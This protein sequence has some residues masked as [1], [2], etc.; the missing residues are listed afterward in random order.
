MK[1]ACFIIACMITF[2]SAGRVGMWNFKGGYDLFEFENDTVYITDNMVA[3]SNKV[4]VW[5]I[6]YADSIID[7]PA[8]FFLIDHS[9]SM[10]FDN[11][12]LLVN[13]RY[14]NRFSFVS[15]VIDTLSI[16][17][18]TM[19]IGYAIFDGSMYL[20]D[21]S[22]YIFASYGAG[23]QAY[24]PLLEL[25]GVYNVDSRF[26]KRSGK[27]ILQSYLQTHLVP[28]D[29]PYNPGNV[30]DYAELQYYPRERGGDN[31]TAA[32]S[33][34]K[35]AFYSSTRP[36]TSHYIVFISDGMHAGDTGYIRGI[37]VP[38]TFTLFLTEN[39]DS[40]PD[41][42]ITM[43]RNIRNNRYSISNPKSTIC[44]FRDVTVS[45]VVNLLKDSI[46]IGPY[47]RP[48][49]P[50]SIILNGQR[51]YTWNQLNSTFSFDGVFPLKSGCTSFNGQ[52]H[53]L[54]KGD[55]DTALS[56]DFIAKQSDAILDSSRI[57]S[58][59][60][61]RTL[62]L[63]YDDA[64]ITNLTPA[65]DAVELRFT[66]DP[67]DALYNYTNVYVELRT[68]NTGDREVVQL[69][70]NDRTF[71]ALIKRT[72]S[73]SAAPAN[74]ILEN[75]PDGDT[76]LAVFRNSEA[77]ILPLDT[78]KIAIPFDP[79][80]EIIHDNAMRKASG[81]RPVLFADNG[82]LRI[83]PP[84]KEACF[85]TVY[86]LSGK[87]IASRTVSRETVSLKV[88]KGVCM[89]FLRSKK[90][91]NMIKEGCIIRKKLVSYK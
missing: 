15:S 81:T 35:E 55:K 83:A 16:K 50:D 90:C 56:I 30:T 6:F 9:P 68:V 44:F 84:G 89:V 76:V 36:H 77:P 18:P 23:V 33:V 74:T 31:F 73:A 12:G 58:W 3:M 65:M 41:D 29:P 24:M 14:G 8:V 79:S 2:S 25:G 32:F 5:N 67:G 52:V 64:S 53:Y 43:T 21:T 11:S 28:L 61:S 26:P 4:R 75:H 70:R 37:D 72:S 47:I 34:A 85:L 1:T 63:Y 10:S 39:G 27:E 49:F 42:L 91:N 54:M 86:S 7:T 51:A 80:A 38:A 45:Y 40:M 48:V 20:A 62:S 59:F 17:Y 82:M 46:N 22:D 71:S 19:E 66:F 88:P 13:D 69:S 60:W 87:L 78:L 57:N